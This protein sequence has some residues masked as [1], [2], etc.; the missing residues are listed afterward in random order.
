MIDLDFIEKISWIFG[1][2]SLGVMAILFSRTF[3]DVQKTTELIKLE[4]RPWVGPVSGD[5]LSESRI[6]N[7]EKFLIKIKNFG[8]TPAKNVTV[9][10]ITQDHKL[11]RE[12]TKKSQ[13]IEN[14]NLGSLLPSM[15]TSYWFYID[16]DKMQKARSNSTEV[17]IGLYISYD[18]EKKKNGYGIIGHFDSHE[19][20]FVKT[21]MW[22][23]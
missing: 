11:N 5:I 1:Y 8:G 14:D 21:E 3:R 13:D 16:S 9:N 6:Y 18:F 12:K 15:E 20:D 19:N 10:F 23:D 4:S 22:E 17:Y 2:S 7:K